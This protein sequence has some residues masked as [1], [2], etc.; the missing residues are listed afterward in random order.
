[1]VVPGMLASCRG[2]CVAAAWDLARPLLPAGATFR[3]DVADHD[4]QEDRVVAE[5]VPRPALR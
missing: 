5:Q 2:F 1:V 3:F 4:E